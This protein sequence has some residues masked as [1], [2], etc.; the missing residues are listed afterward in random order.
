MALEGAVAVL[1]EFKA[2]AQR[3]DPTAINVLGEIWLISSVI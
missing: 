2:Q 3:G 1:T